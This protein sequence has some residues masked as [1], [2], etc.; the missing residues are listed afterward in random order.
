MDQTPPN[1]SNSRLVMATR[2]ASPIF[3]LILPVLE[4]EKKLALST[5]HQNVSTPKRN[6]PVRMARIRR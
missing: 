2:T 3:A 1:K 4:A 6:M 5:A